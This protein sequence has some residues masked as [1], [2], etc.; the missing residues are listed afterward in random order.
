M[1]TRAV[2]V[3][4]VS[5]SGSRKCGR[6]VS[7]VHADAS[8]PGKNWSGVMPMLPTLSTARVTVTLP[9]VRE[10]VVAMVVVMGRAST[11][12]GQ[13]GSPGPAYPWQG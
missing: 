2:L 13:A 1:A 4:A 8:V 7:S 12:R 9:K 3:S 11:P 6:R 5:P 10:W